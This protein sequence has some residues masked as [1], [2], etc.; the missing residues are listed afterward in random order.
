M[1]QGCVVTSAVSSNLVEQFIKT[2]IQ[3]HSL[4]A[5]SKISLKTVYKDLDFEIVAYRTSSNNGLV[6]LSNKYFLA[7]SHQEVIT[8][9]RDSDIIILNQNQI[10]QVLT[11]IPELQNKIRLK[12]IKHPNEEEYIDFSIKEN[13]Y[14][15]YRKDVSSYKVP[16]KINLWIWDVKHTIEAGEL[17]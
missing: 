11:I 12:K 8:V 4:S 5:Y 16:D 10:T 9:Y 3:K 1:I 14:L 6:L 7:H 15:S 17:S 2:N 13:F